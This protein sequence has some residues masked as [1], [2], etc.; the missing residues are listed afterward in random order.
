MVESGCG[1]VGCMLHL[2]DMITPSHIRSYCSSLIGIKETLE[3]L[4]EHSEADQEE[5]QQQL[6]HLEGICNPIVSKVYQQASGAPQG[7]N[8]DDDLDI[9]HDEL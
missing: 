7:R 5:F 2:Y 9:N 4:E 3:W 8:D 1:C 6:K